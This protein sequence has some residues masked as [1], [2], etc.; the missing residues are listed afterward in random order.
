MLRNQKIQNLLAGL[1]LAAL[2]GHSASITLT[3]S[4]SAGSSTSFN[5]AGHWSNTAAPS[6]GNTYDTTASWLIRTP[7]VA[8]SFSFAGASLQLTGP[9]TTTAGGGRIDLSGT[10]TADV[11]TIGNLIATNLAMIQNG[12]LGGATLPLAGALTI[13]ADAVNSFGTN[14]CIFLT[15]NGPIL[16][17][18]SVSGSGAI[19]RGTPSAGANG[20]NLILAGD[21]S[22]FSGKIITTD[23]HVTCPVTVSNVTDQIIPGQISILDTF[24]K[25]GV[26]KLTLTGTNSNIGTTVVS[27]GTLALAGYEAAVTN[28]TTVSSGATLQLQANATNIVNGTNYSLGTAAAAANTFSVGSFIQF[29]SDSSVIFNGGANLGGVGNG[30]NSWDVNQLTGAGANNTLTFAPAGFNV[31]NSTF[32]ITGGNGYT[33][34]VGP[35]NLIST[36]GTLTL[37]ASNANLNVNGITS[38]GASGLTTVLGSSNTTISAAITAT[39][40]LTKQ[41]T[42]KLTLN[43]ANTFVGST[44]IQTG[45]V[46][47]ASGT[48]LASTNLNLSAGATLDAGALGSALAMNSSQLLMGKGTVNGSVDT[49]SGGVILPGGNLAAGTLTVTTNL[50]LSSGGTLKFDLAHNTAIGG[51]TNDL[52]VVGGNLNV[53]GSTTLGLNFLNGSP[54]TGVY[55]LIQYGTISGDTTLASITLPS[56]PRYSL[57]LSNDT[58]NKA[59]EL[60]VAGVPGTL[61]WLGDGINNGW[62]NAGSYQSWTNIASLSL[63]YFYDGDNVTFNDSGSDSPVINITTVNSPGSLTVN[64]TQN[65]DFTGSGGIAGVASL[66]KS[67]SGTLILETA[68]TYTGPTVINGG[69]LQI[70]NANAS[71]TLGTSAV[72]NNGTLTFNRTDGIGLA[73]DLHGTGNI[74]YNGTGSVTPTSVNNDYTGST[75]VNNGILYATTGAAFGQSSGTTVNSGAQVYITANVNIGAEPLTL[76]G[77]GLHKGASG[78]TIYGGALTLSSNSTINVDGGATLILT[79][80]A[81]IAGGSNALATAGSGTLTLGGPVALGT[82]SLTINS[83]TLNLNSSNF[84]SG[85]TTLT[86]GVVNVNTNGALGSGP[87]TATTSGRFVIGTGLTITNAFTAT[88]VNPGAATGFLMTSDNT[89]GTVTTI[90]GPL[91][92]GATPASGGS[93][94][95]PTS[96]GYLNIVGSISSAPSTAVTVRFGNARFSGSGNYPE[97]QVRANTT[98]LGAYNGIATNAVM[99]LAGN[100]AAFFDLN[101][102]NQTLAGLKNT[103]TPANA[104]LGYITNSSATATTLNLNLGTGN[105]YTFGGHV[106]GNLALVVSSGTQTL[107]GTNGY[108]GSTT[109]NGGT[110]ELANAT[111]ATNS[112]VTITNGALLQLDFSTTNQIGALV[113][114]GVSQAPGVYN[115][116][117]SP[118]YI[119]G[120]G[121]LIVPATGPGTFTVSPTVTGIAL[122]GANVSFTGTGGQAGDA[123]Y[124][125]AG[126]NVAQPF[127]Q[128]R[129]VATNV[130]ATSGSFTFTGT[131]AVIVGSPQQFYI[132]SNT[133]YN[134]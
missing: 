103:V 123:Y 39:T 34:A 97:L 13:K 37:N 19:C 43:G 74:V 4:D 7:N 132:L 86:A 30:I 6:S 109:V 78:V 82:N 20:Y 71:G 128:W 25:Q 16:L 79:N 27:A 41:G 36:G 114:N 124:L 26:A 62:D 129:T 91:I 92:F 61:V 107:T 56:N 100:G 58:V 5:A 10:S 21:L 46:A 112:T 88:T 49:A 42:G 120:S 44:L 105:T 48:T 73:N 72:T 11:I 22:G 117:T 83:G 116:T 1:L 110:L 118:T 68:N 55:T 111:I 89:N 80:A 9:G 81:G 93:F 106:V 59:V 134:P 133:N 64:A 45:T 94:A 99:D 76:A 67:G 75:V 126:T 15:G 66:T 29:R 31:L 108:L 12:G 115:S 119:T 52:I 102:Y 17:T 14:G 24:T 84:Y 125:L 51:G 33:L 98:S 28:T 101:G 85:G 53:A 95:G 130:L 8:G 47:L 50:T 65:Y 127:S 69:T 63:D 23:H 90:S 57:S 60:V 2:T 3:A 122:A 87:V 54:V 40:A 96:S 70:G 77:A 35:M 18:A 38:A 131:N 104:A 32:N 121:N 113:L